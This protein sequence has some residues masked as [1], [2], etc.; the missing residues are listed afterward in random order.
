MAVYAAV[1]L[2][3]SYSLYFI[4]AKAKFQYSYLVV[5]VFIVFSALLF[6]GSIYSSFAQLELTL[7]TLLIGFVFVIALLQLKFTKQ[8]WFCFFYFVIVLGLLQFLIA[9]VQQFDAFSIFYLWTG[10]FPFKFNNHYLGS[11]QQ[12]NMLASF[13]A[14]VVVVSAWLIYSYGFA[15]Q[16]YLLQ[17]LVWVSLFLGVFII[18]GSGSRVGLLG[19]LIALL[20]LFSAFK[21]QIKNQTKIF[22]L[23]LFVAFMAFVLGSALTPGY[24]HVSNKLHRVAEGNDIR[25]FLYETGVHIFWQNIWFGVGIGN[26][27]EAFKA[28]VLDNGWFLDKR[29]VDWDLTIFLHPHNE[30][31]YWV[32]E[33][34]LVG[35]LPM[36]IALFL[37]LINWWKQGVKKFLL[38]S[39]IS[40]PLFLQMMVSYPT[41]LS[42]L[43]YFL[44][45][46]LIVW[47]VKLP[48]YSVRIP[49]VKGLKLA[50][51]GVTITLVFGIFYNVYLGLMSTFE[52]Y[53][54]KNR[55]FLY[56]TYPQQENSGYF[57]HASKFKIYDEIILNNMEN[58]Y[59]NALVKGNI[60]DLNQYLLW[61]KNYNKNNELPVRFHDFAESAKSK[62]VINGK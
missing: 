57:Y 30:L 14:F 47:S 35:V 40:F 26:Y 1:G 3:I 53:Y 37:L 49:C 48:P 45:I 41:I 4:F 22:Y 44:A 17:I 38:Y 42:A 60:Y 29:I 6:S 43:H 59:K 62:L 5:T 36:L 2:F 39:A 9:V 31:L 8:L 34:G 28:F 56:K 15:K 19:G 27:P 13:A 54:F 12:I 55:I 21:E 24:E 20:L 61:Y 51:A 7:Y 46:I 50:M 52:A 25:W 18:A 32:V 33:A 10:Y 23:I 11:L 16:H 58:M